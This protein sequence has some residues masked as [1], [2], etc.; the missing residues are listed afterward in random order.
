MKKNDPEKKIYTL[1]SSIENAYEYLNHLLQVEH[2]DHFKSWANLKGLD[3]ND[4]A[5]WTEYIANCIELDEIAQYVVSKVLY[6]NESVAAM[7][8]IFA[9]CIPLNCSFE[10][11]SEMKK[12]L[13]DTEMKAQLLEALKKAEAEGKAQHD[14]NV[15]E[16]G[17]IQKQVEEIKKN[18]DAYMKSIADEE[19]L[20]DEFE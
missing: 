18:I 4:E 2:F 1:T 7:L 6:T 15:E 11:P 16:S 12:Y 14:K 13:Q 5:T 10:H 20:P 19:V 8:R 17:D 3:I 9:K